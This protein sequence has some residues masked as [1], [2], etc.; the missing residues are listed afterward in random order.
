MT[1]LIWMLLSRTVVYYLLLPVHVYGLMD[2]WTNHIFI[3]LLHSDPG[4]VRFVCGTK[5]WGIKF[6]LKWNK[7]H[8]KI[9]KTVGFKWGINYNNYIYYDVM[10]FLCKTTT[11]ISICMIIGYISTVYH[12]IMH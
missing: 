8:W 5:V 3:V 2:P 1:A 10:S 7:Q 6:G 11:S 9:Y 12:A 4:I